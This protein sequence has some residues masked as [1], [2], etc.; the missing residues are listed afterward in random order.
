MIITLGYAAMIFA[1][2]AAVYGIVAIIIGQITRS[3]IWTRSGRQACLVLFPLFSFSVGSL[4]A[5]LIRNDYQVDYVFQTVNNF[6][7]LYLKIS[8]LWGKQSGSLL[9]W[10][11]I[12]SLFL[13]IWAIQTKPEKD[14]LFPT[15]AIF[16]LA[17][18]AF[19][20]IL[21]IWIDNPFDRYWQTGEMGTAVLSIFPAGNDLPL[22]PSDGLGMNPLL[23]H[24]GM[25]YHP[26]ALYLGFIAVF[27]TAAFEI[28][29]LIHRPADDSWMKKVRPWAIFTWIFLAVGLILG[30]RWA[31]DVLGW[32]GYWGWDPVEVAALIPFLLMTAYL[33][34]VIGHTATGGF[35]RWSTV[36]CLL[37]YGSIVFAV[38]V[39]R[40]GLISS[41]H[42]FSV[43]PLSV[44]LSVYLA[45]T[46]LLIAS[47]IVARRRTFGSAASADNLD[48]SA[49]IQTKESLFTA[50]IILLCIIAFFCLWGILLP[51]LSELFTGRQIAIGVEYYE[52]STGPLFALLLLVM[53]IVP[54]TNWKKPLTAKQRAVLG[55]LALIAGIAAVIF[56]TINHLPG[57]LLPLVLWVLFFS[58]LAI[59]YTWGSALFMRAKNTQPKQSRRSPGLIRFFVG[60]LIHAGVILMAF[61]IIGI[62]FLQIEEQIKL[63][64]NESKPAAGFELTLTGA[65]RSQSDEGETLS[66]TVEI[67]QN[68]RKLGAVH[69]QQKYYA[70]YN[71]QTTVPGIRSALSG[72]LY[73]IL[74][75]SESASLDAVRTYTVYYNPWINWLWI[76]SIV[77]CL[78]GAL[79]FFGALKKGAVRK[80]AAAD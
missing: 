14:P 79:L 29:A 17:N 42:A 48:F 31:Y 20:S 80:D 50:G 54:L 34:A 44:F 23:R 69:P 1:F 10:S 60:Y 77:L 37:T 27:F 49:K 18:L 78:G 62:E 68:G 71:Q 55:A 64:P 52:K 13:F 21:H 4:L 61:G 8:A 3:P 15:A 12:F 47:L 43:S 65:D 26:P 30:S 41:V 70:S 40:S 72:D 19:T 5:L 75:G 56:R 58:I 39:T 76:G 7:P 2:F 53:G 32:G 63:T 73:L 74:T 38:F 24:F 66:T 57:L 35:R 46:I 9:F 51:N 67:S 33:H 28:S 59:L 45:A 16:L 25:V 22:I 11:W 6:Q 36:L